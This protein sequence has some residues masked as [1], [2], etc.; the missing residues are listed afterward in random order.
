MTTT[1]ALG[2]EQTPQPSPNSDRDRTTRGI[3][4]QRLL[5]RQNRVYRGTGGVS[6]HN[7]RSGFVPAYYD[8]RS[9]RAVV[10]CFADGKP[11]PVHVLD[12]LPAE[13]VET[14]DAKGRVTKARTGVVAGFL[15]DGIFFTREAAAQ[16]V[17]T[18]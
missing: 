2:I 8:V 16:A 7:R 3:L 17:K 14:R 12:G 18:Q 6:Q 1:Q 5:R 13:W 11:A 15:R 9:G 10:S 4:S